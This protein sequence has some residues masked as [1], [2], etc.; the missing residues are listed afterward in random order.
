[1]CPIG[2]FS[3]WNN[4][5]KPDKPL[6]AENPRMILDMKITIS[7]DEVN[8]AYS[9]TTILVQVSSQCPG[10]VCGSTIQAR[11]DLYRGQTNPYAQQF[12]LNRICVFTQRQ[13]NLEGTNARVSLISSTSGADALAKIPLPTHRSVTKEIPRVRGLIKPASASVKR[14][15]QKHYKVVRLRRKMSTCVF[16]EKNQA[17]SWSK[18][19]RGVV[20]HEFVARMKHTGAKSVLW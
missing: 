12:I 16:Q 5:C 1:M 9:P 11:H 3:L 14:P 10:L 2:H 13:D 17:S 15:T 7:I 19:D 18:A 4:S 8:L 6:L 20:C